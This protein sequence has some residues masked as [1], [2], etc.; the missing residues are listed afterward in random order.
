MRHLA[1]L[2]IARLTAPLTDPRLADFVGALDRV[3]ALADRS[4]G[5]VWRLAG[6]GGDATDIAWAADPRVIV[7]L[8]VWEDAPSLERF[9]F[10]TVHRAVYARRAEWFEAM[11]RHHF[12]MWWVEAGHRPGLAEA[13]ARLARLETEGSSEHAFGWERVGT[14]LAGRAR[15]GPVAAE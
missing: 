11:E 5:F 6:E 2:N 13:A 7:N 10:E 9:V 8:S 15:C 12:V 4:P 14:G 1:E 3:N